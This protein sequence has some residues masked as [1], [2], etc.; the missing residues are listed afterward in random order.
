VAFFCLVFAFGH[1]GTPRA[2]CSA[3]IIADEG[4]KNKL[5]AHCNEQFT[6]NKEQLSIVLCSLR[7]AHIAFCAQKCYNLDAR[8]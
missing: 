1:E 4:E 8:R 3:D 7:E 6:M 5:E 2:F